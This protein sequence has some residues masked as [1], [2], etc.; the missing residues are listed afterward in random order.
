[1]TDED[2]EQLFD[3]TWYSFVGG[4]LIGGLVGLRE[5]SVRFIAENRDTRFISQYHAQR[6]LNNNILMASSKYGLKWGLKVGLF[7]TLFA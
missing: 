7:G 6:E 5:S 2:V 1:M 3:T 4:G